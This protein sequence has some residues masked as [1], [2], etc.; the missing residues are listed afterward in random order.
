MA[1]KTSD[2]RNKLKQ[3]LVDANITYQRVNEQ[4]N[5]ES[6]SVKLV[7]PNVSFAEGQRPRIEM[8]QISSTTT[9][10]TLKGNTRKQERGIYDFQVVVPFNAGEQLADELC[11]KI[12]NVYRSGSYIQIPNGV[13]QFPNSP[14]IGQ[15]VTHSDIEGRGFVILGYIATNL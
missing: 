4:G 7:F 9:D 12:A 11:D 10:D 5:T 6:E 2:V 3:M 13:I 1:F 8:K 14:S 15:F